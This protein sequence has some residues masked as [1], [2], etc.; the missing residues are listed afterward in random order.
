MSGLVAV[1]LM[2]L[3]QEGKGPTLYDD[4]PPILLPQ[5]DPLPP[6]PPPGSVF[7]EFLMVVD[8]DRWRENDQLTSLKEQAGNLFFGVPLIIPQLALEEFLPRG[9]AVGPST[10]LY[11]TPKDSRSLSFVIFDQAIF[12]E[13]EFVEQAQARAALGPSAPESLSRSQSNVLRRSLM[14]GFRACYTLPNMSLDT[15]AETVEEQG[16]WGYLVAPAAGGALLYLKGF[17][18]RFSIE[19]VV[20]AR[21]KVSSLRQW[22]RGF[23]SEQGVPALSCEIRIGHL[24]LAVIFSVEMTDRGPISQFAGLGTTLDVVEDLLG[25]EES[26][27]DYSAQ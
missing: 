20:Q 11:R 25:R 17:D 9:L 6:N 13:E 22:T 3:G 5:S 12:H 7:P 15:I 18:Q 24:P 26:R 2:V 4:P 10:Y 1:A 21:I 8:V 14:T 16:V 27:K 23:R 19:D